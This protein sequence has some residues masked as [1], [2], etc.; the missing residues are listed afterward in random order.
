MIMKLNVKKLRE[1]KET[2]IVSSKDAL[3]DVT[4]IAWSEEIINGNKK[5]TIK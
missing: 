1:C 5:I 4:K 2:I 3:S